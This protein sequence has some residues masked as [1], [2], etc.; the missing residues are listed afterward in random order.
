V[1]NIQGKGKKMKR[2]NISSIAVVVLMRQKFSKSLE[3]FLAFAHHI[4][5]NMV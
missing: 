3:Q 2:G 1:G 4:E 5:G